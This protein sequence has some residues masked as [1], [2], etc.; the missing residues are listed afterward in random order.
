MP[1]R[2]LD[3]AVE[4]PEGIAEQLAVLRGELEIPDRF[5]AEV[6]AAAE[7]AAGHGD[8]PDH[9]RTDLEMVTIDPEGA[10]DLDQ[11]M[12]LERDGSGYVVWYAIADLPAF[13]IAGDPIDVEARLRGQTLYA[14]DRRTPLHP[15]AL[16]EGA[17]SL[18][19]GEVRPCYLW[20]IALG[21]SGETT[22]A[23]VRRALVRSREQLTYE[24]VQGQLDEGTASESLS[25]LAEI[26]PLRQAIEARRGGISLNLP[27]QEIQP[28]DGEWHLVFREQLPVE[29]WNAQISLLTGIAAA[30]VMIAGKL[31]VLR[32]LPPADDRSVRRLRRGAR[33]LGLDWPAQQG[34]P[35][36]VRALDPAIPTHVAML[37]SCTTLFRGAGYES[38]SGEVPAQVQHAALAAPYAHAT[39]PLR[40]LGDRWV[41][42]ICA[43]LCADEPAPD[44][45]RQ[46][47][48]DIPKIMTRSDQHAK[49]YERAVVDLVEAHRLAPRIG[50]EFP[51][52]IID[53]DDD[54]ERGTVMVADPA[55]EATV[56][57][58]ALPLGE[59]VTVRLAIADPGQRTVEFELAG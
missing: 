59:E 51:A 52:V 35:E 28:V 21:A 53:V 10:K 14:P 1:S 45:V 15:A 32:T 9:D 30:Q 4:V 46:S 3:F 49:R 12:F 43:A 13:V 7:L 41:L 18:L 22:D 29:G 24:Q 6:D 38:F 27:E 50:Q 19:A 17:A 11:A 47:M 5:P 54:G 31:G 42:A 48:D 16:S 25:L 33:A 40:R 58:A 44:W 36:F 20:R 37:N 39:A 2:H 34:Y 8:L 55:V 23:S 56:H 26:G 57:G